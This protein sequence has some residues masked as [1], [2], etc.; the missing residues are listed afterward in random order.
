M[1]GAAEKPKRPEPEWEA[2]GPD[3]LPDGAIAAVV[4]LLIDLDEK[5]LRGELKE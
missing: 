3:R 1:I 4:R 2:R 5:R